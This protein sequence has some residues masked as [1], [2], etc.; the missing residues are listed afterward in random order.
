M[1]VGCGDKG[2]ALLQKN[3]FCSQNDKF[4]CIFQKFLTGWIRRCAHPKYWPY[5]FF[6]SVNF[7]ELKQRLTCVSILDVKPIY[8]YRCIHLRRLQDHR[9]T[10][11]YLECWCKWLDDCNLRCRL[12]T[13]LCL[14][15]VITKQ[16]VNE[17]FVN[18]VNDTSIVIGTRWRAHQRV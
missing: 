2:W 16:D 7:G 15:N 11:S 13:R 6:P 4:G 5:L 10:W 14:Q 17:N 18:N 12:H 1:E 3:H 8:L 9:Y